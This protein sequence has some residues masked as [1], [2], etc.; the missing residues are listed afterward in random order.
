MSA[1]NGKYAQQYEIAPSLRIPFLFHLHAYLIL[2]LILF[3]VFF[4]YF[5]VHVFCCIILEKGNV[6]RHAKITPQ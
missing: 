5:N 3:S 1:V 6:L 4:S 2:R